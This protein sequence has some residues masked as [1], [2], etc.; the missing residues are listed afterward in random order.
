M[1]QMQKAQILGMANTPDSPVSSELAE[2]L[3]E[4]YDTVKITAKDNTV[5]YVMPKPEKMDEFVES[6][7]PGVISLFE[8]VR[9]AR[10]A[11][12]AMSRKN[13]M[14]QIGLAFHNYHDVYNQFPAADGNGESGRGQ[15]TGLSWRVYLLPFVE[16]AALYSQFKMDEDWDSPHNKAL[17]EK[18]PDVFK[19]EGVDKP[20]Y[21][22]VHVFTGDDTAIGGNGKGI[23]DITDGTANT[24]LAVVAGPDTAEIWTKPGGLEFNTDNPKKSLGKIGDVFLALLCDG[25]VRFVKSDIADET[26]RKLIQRNDGPPMDEF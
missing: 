24:I 7:K 6:M 5:S 10:K 3:S 22:S 14:K 12:A 4:L 1:L 19:V 18:M 11:S 13:N 26:L 9:S 8:A 23:P 2:K 25:S 15:K 20:G 21:T 17:I 16:E